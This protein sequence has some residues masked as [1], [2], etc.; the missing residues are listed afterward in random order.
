MIASMVQ[1]RDGFEGLLSRHRDVIEAEI[2]KAM[3]D[4]EIRGLEREDLFQMCMIA[5]WHSQKRLLTAKEPPALL[6]TICNRSIKKHIVKNSRD[7][8]A[9]AVSLSIIKEP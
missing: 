1:G 4:N 6:R 7:L 2:A 5:A 8:L 3:K 9:T